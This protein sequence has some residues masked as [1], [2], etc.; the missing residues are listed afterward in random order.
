MPNTSTNSSELSKLKVD[1][2]PEE[3]TKLAQE[4]VEQ[5]KKVHDEVASLPAERCNFESVCKR[6][7]LLEGWAETEASNCTFPQ[8]VFTDKAVREASSNATA[9]IE[10]VDIE[11]SMRE[12]LYQAVLN[13]KAKKEKL[14]PEEQRLLDKMELDFKRNGLALP[15]EQRD[16]LAEIKKRIS[17]LRIEF[18]KN[19]NEDDSKLAF[20]AKELQGVKPEFLE[21]LEKVDP[22]EA[23][24]EEQYYVSTKYPDLFPVLKY[25]ENDEV[26]HKMDTLN[27]TKCKPNVAILEEVIELRKQMAD[28]M[29]YSDFASFRLE[30]KMAKDSATVTEF[31]DDLTAKLKP[32]ATKELEELKNVKKAEKEAHNQA[33]D[34][35]FHSYD[36]SY[37]DR[38]QVERDFQVDESEIQKYFPV[39]HVVKVVFDLYQEVL[40]V[41]F[42]E[43]PDA[44]V[45]HSDV[46]MYKVLDAKTNELMGSF[47]LDLHPREGKYNHAA[48]FPLNPGYETEDGQRQMP[49]AAMVANFTKPTAT[50]PSLLRHSEAVTYLHELGHVMHNMC[51]KTQ[52][53]R[54][55]GTSVEGDFVEA[56]SQMLENWCWET[57]VLKRLSSH[58]ETKE[59][60]GQELIDRMLAAKNHN[61]GLFNLR[62]I[63]FGKFDMICHTSKDKIDTTKLWNE[64]K[65]EIS[66]VPANPDGYP[67]ASYAHIIA[68][69]EAGYYGYLYSLVFSTDMFYTRFKKEGLFASKA[70]LEYRS[71]ILQPG[72]SRDAQDMLLDFIGRKFNQEAFLKSIGL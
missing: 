65:P 23:G 13:A 6:L 39:D 40:A 33:Y 69:Y 67:A 57:D 54:F 63:F 44:K 32:I 31:L 47:Y 9:E 17:E 2:S 62:Q 52:F 10:K 24:K 43:V 53:A 46:K 16:K 37:Y 50:R 11:E 42:V 72:G 29:G 19:L 3:I 26:R 51:A 35:S 38:I 41:K 58:H 68:G 45:W 60:I 48:C 20:T 12:D 55:H 27:A 49:V 8:Y 61:A 14:N 25:A 59:P 36:Y 15:K 71:K 7:A 22:V 56:P 28:I 5:T 34:G 66:L 30:V 4:I 64:L 21:G 18:Q 70:G 1:L